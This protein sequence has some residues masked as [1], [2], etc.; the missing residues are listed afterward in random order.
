MSLGLKVIK[1]FD[2][3]H[4]HNSYSPSSKMQPAT[5]SEL[6]EIE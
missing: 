2:G 5:W 4:N 6:I 3:Q 1:L